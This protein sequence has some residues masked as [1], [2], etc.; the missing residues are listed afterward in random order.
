VLH[1][2]IENSQKRTGLGPHHSWRKLLNQSWKPTTIDVLA[3]LVAIITAARN[4]L[5]VTIYD[6]GF[7]VINVYLSYWG[8]SDIAP[9]KPRYVVGGA[10][11]VATLFLAIAMRY[12]LLKQGRWSLP[13]DTPNDGSM[14]YMF[15]RIGEHFAVVR[16]NFLRLGF[17]LAIISCWLIFVCFGSALDDKRQFVY[18]VENGLSQHP[19]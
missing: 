19:G 18:A 1:H 5:A 11:L 16:K 7:L 10:W 17:T 12:F 8:A 3:K 13:H 2:T 14:R 15:V 6:A 4:G 9:A